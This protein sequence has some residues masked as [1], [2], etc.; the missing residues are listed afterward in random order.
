[1][2]QAKSAIVI[3]RRFE[4]ACK[5][6]ILVLFWLFAVVLAACSGAQDPQTADDATAED[7]ETST[8]EPEVQDDLTPL[9][10][11]PVLSIPSAPIW[12][13][14]DQGY[15]EDVGLDVEMLL[16]PSGT[17]ALEAFRQGQGD[18]VGTGDLPGLV[19]WAT[20]DQET[21]VIMSPAFGPERF[22]AVATAEIQ[23]PEDLVGKTIGI[24]EGSGSEYFAQR[25]LELNDVDEGD[26]I[27]ANLE[28]GQ[29]TA[30]LSNKD[31]DAFFIWDPHGGQALEA[32][33]DTG[34]HELSTATGY[35]GG[36]SMI[37]GREAWLEDNEET[38]L[39]FIEATER[40]LDFA[41]DNLD[42][43][44]EY[45]ERE[46]QMDSELVAS[47]Y[48]KSDWLVTFLDEAFFEEMSNLASW[49]TDK[50]MIEEE[51]DI[52]SLVWDP[53]LDLDDRSV[54]P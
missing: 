32:L 6:R 27:F 36:Y 13:A 8:A 48:G 39:A 46:F 35:M 26:V 33:G 9:T 5:S 38:V 45:A 51:V 22:S 7:T 12:M 17:T 2:L 43:V 47:E 29:M 15:Y 53:V 11:M 23:A 14:H 20:H 40:G 52:G 34:V 4:R 37:S 54:Q 18:L 10:I 30:A 21:R 31:I 28:P 19:Y 25:Y 42:Y 49:A 1:M 41:Q 3:R 50:G 44:G 16:F 24:R